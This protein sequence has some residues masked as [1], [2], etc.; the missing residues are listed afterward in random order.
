MFLT[1]AQ[2]PEWLRKFDFTVPPPLGVANPASDNPV[3][4]VSPEYILDQ[5]PVSPEQQHRDQRGRPIPEPLQLVNINNN[6]NNNNDSNNNTF[7]CCSP[8]MCP[9]CC[10]GTTYPLPTIPGPMDF[11]PATPTVSYFNYT[12]GLLRTSY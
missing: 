5:L 7:E 10:S 2:D 6:D 8:D 9:T 3:N 1:T 4:P 11:N 12:R